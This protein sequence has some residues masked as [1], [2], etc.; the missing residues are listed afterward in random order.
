MCF[1]TTPVSYLVIT[2]IRFRPKI[3]TEKL[4]NAELEVA[5][6]IHVPATGMGAPKN[7]RSHDGPGRTRFL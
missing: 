1:P 2:R 3:R 4:L 7:R 5:G 6:R